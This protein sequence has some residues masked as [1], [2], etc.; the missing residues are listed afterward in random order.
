[1]TRFVYRRTI[2]GVLAVGLAVVLPASVCADMVPL[3]VNPAAEHL[4]V[5]NPEGSNIYRGPLAAGAVVVHFFSDGF[6]SVEPWLCE[7]ETILVGAQAN[8]VMFQYPGSTT[9][10]GSYWTTGQSAGGI[11]W[12]YAYTAWTQQ[13]QPDI[14]NNCPFAVRNITGYTNYYRA[15]A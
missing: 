4:D 1:M 2:A 3:A 5:A 7:V 11:D 8:D 13:D 14:K 10:K 15:H 9:P 12:S 6:S